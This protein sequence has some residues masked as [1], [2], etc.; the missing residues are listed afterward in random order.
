MKSDISR[1]T[2][3]AKKH[4][5][6]VRLQQGQ[7]HLDADWNEQ[8]DILN[9]AGRTSTADIMGQSGVPIKNS[10]FNISASD[11]QSELMISP[12]RIYVDG[13]LCE[14]Q[15]AISVSD[16]DDFPEATLPANDG[17]YLAYLEVWE[18]NITT[19][20]DPSLRE[21][22]LG[23]AGS[24]TRSQVMSQVKLLPVADPTQYT[25]HHSEPTEWLALK[26]RHQNRGKLKAQARS[27]E[28]VSDPCSYGARGGYTRLENQLYR[29][30][31]H[32]GGLP[33]EATFKWS[34]NNGILVTEWLDQDQNILTVRQTGKDDVLKFTP[35]QWIEL[36]D[37]GLELAGKRGAL[38]QILDVEGLTITINP[39]N[40]VL[41]DTDE[42]DLK[43][44]DFS[45]G[46]AKI[47][48]WDMEDHFG[49]IT[50][51]A[52]SSTWVAVEE[53][54]EIQ[55][56]HDA[57]TL[58]QS[59]DY[60]LIPARA[61][62]KNIE[63]PCDNQSEPIA[64]E[65]HGVTRHFCRLAFVQKN[66]TWEVLSDCR[67]TSGRLSYVSGD[68]QE[69]YPG[70]VLP[71]PLKVLVSN[72]FTPLPDARV[73]FRVAEG[74]G[75]ILQLPDDSGGTI[76]YIAT[77]DSKGIA[78]CYWKPGID[79]AQVHQMVHAVLLNE[80]NE[81]LAVS[82][83][84]NANLNTAQET[85]Y[86]RPLVGE[87]TSI[88]GNNTDLMLG[89]NNVQSGLDKLNQIKVNRTGDTITGPLTVNN[90]LTV[91]L[92]SEFENDLTIRGT[93]YV[94]GDVI[95]KDEDHLPGDIKLGD[96]DEDTITI[97]GTIVSEHTSD[98][99]E[100]NDSLHV[101]G[102]AVIDGKLGVGT[103]TPGAKLEVNSGDVS[104]L[105]VAG[106]STP[107]ADSF[108]AF[109]SG[110][111]TSPPCLV[112]KENNDL[113][114]GTAQDFS[115]MT[116][117]QKVLLTSTGRVGI[118]NVNPEEQLHVKESVRI[119]Q[120]LYV[121]GTIYSEGAGDVTGD[122]TVH[123]NTILGDND[124]HSLTIRGP[125]RSEHSSGSIQ[126]DDSVTINESL[127]VDYSVGIG[128]SNPRAKLEVIDS[129]ILGGNGVNVI[130][131]A[132]DNFPESDETLNTWSD[133]GAFL[134]APMIYRSKFFENVNGHFPFDNFGELVLQGTTHG[135]NFNRGITFVTT[136]E[137]GSPKPRI[138]IDEIGRVGVGTL[139]P[140]QE[141]EVKGTVK[142]DYFEGDGSNLTNILSSQWSD[143]GANAIY[144][145]LGNVG[146]GTANPSSKLDVAGDV[147]VG[148]NLKFAPQNTNLAQ[149]SL[150]TTGDST[151]TTSM[152]FHADGSSIEGYKFYTNNINSVQINQN[153][154]HVNGSIRSNVGTIRDANG[155]WVRTYGSSGW[156]NAS[157]G[158]GWY[159]SDSNWIRSF[160]SKGIYQN[161]GKLRTDGTLQVGD[162]G[163]TL[164]VDNEGALLYREDVLCAI[165]TGRV[166]IGTK[167]PNNARLQVEGDIST[168]QEGIRWLVFKGVISSAPIK[169]THG[170]EDPALIVGINTLVHFEKYL[171]PP[172][173]YIENN[174]GYYR[175]LHQDKD[176]ILEPGP[177]ARFKYAPYKVIIWYQVKV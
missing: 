128:T 165:P 118:G 134:G 120:D 52:D 54:I 28:I 42:P 163:S 167:E 59:G 48:Q 13:I 103:S 94:K 140:V 93:L 131:A 38:A 127:T 159:M 24:A 78:S 21:M 98:S 136:E 3:K 166:G 153:G 125:V 152:E 45:I 135:N 2:F 5:S 145:N 74:D 97:N 80:S 129:T 96:Q 122:L 113:K 12:G 82:I 32:K 8:A 116:F 19:L 75:L 108:I 139:T 58:F 6:S 138:R 68:G 95:A 62:I 43:I 147:Q 115:G 1:S 91:S 44:A 92:A 114:I 79:P 31:I 29:I 155:G 102:D 132:P 16:Q 64:D 76:D 77:S 27:D 7:P 164:N 9:Y 47:R 20:E 65:S 110:Q 117:S 99:L 104:E 70:N 15:E 144:Y 156:R 86:Q 40:V 112:W 142:A 18:R 150:V 71:Y 154:L 67:Y 106:I 30:E 133:T 17:L 119:N 73:L 69:A 101:S 173:S 162:G 61:A 105:A 37:D 158:G 23:K 33:G 41:H 60:W 22:A 72:G 177:E 34:R 176:L 90:E 39:E 89:V 57:K 35:G 51:P 88:D 56:S 124:D 55:F 10:G 123:G 149:V 46:T 151:P 36:T 87:T 26:E 63:W 170:I 100:I 171:F 126:L 25:G 160:G 111:N 148:Q 130:H 83:E 49:E 146:I 11:D 141:V 169:V 174:V 50:I 109:S 107:G 84:F 137:G 172:Y 53:G 14:N 121:G 175:I 161:T 168:G 85:F 81:E 143:G 157:Y 66:G 4:Y